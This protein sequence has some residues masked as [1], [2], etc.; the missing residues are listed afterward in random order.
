VNPNS[1]SSQQLIRT[2]QTSWRR[3]SVGPAFPQ[4]LGRPSPRT[5]R[6]ASW[7]V[8]LLE[9]QAFTVLS[10]YTARLWQLKKVGHGGGRGHGKCGL[11]RLPLPSFHI[12]WTEE[13]TRHRIPRMALATTEHSTLGLGVKA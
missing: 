4:A 9:G 5:P 6:S 3:G 8:D 7:L 13:P 10:V 11:Q 12:A 2:P 1:L